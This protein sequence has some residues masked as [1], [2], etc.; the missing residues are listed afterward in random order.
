MCSERV[1]R[2][3]ALAARTARRR[4]RGRGAGAGKGEY[5]GRE[6][7]GRERRVRCAR[8]VAG[9][10]KSGAVGAKGAFWR[11]RVVSAGRGDNSE[12]E[13]KGDADGSQVHSCGGWNAGGEAHET[14]NSFSRG[15]GPVHT[16][17]TTQ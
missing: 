2:V 11:V 12:E 4:S 14:S 10:R 8:C 9:W 1:R 15:A 16:I 13:G 3:R 5:E 7:M 17:S 6:G